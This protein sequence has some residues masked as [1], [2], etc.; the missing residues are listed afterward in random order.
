MRLRA[1]LWG[2]GGGGAGTGR[3]HCV[4]QNVKDDF[5]I[6]YNPIT[7][8]K[9]WSLVQTLDLIKRYFDCL[10]F[11]FLIFLT[12]LFSKRYSLPCHFDAWIYRRI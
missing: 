2:G 8:G 4:F 10:M 3:V 1:A 5:K 7:G 9:V 6:W 12:L 11:N